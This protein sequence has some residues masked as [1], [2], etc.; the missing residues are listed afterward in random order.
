[1]PN[2][3]CCISPPEMLELKAY[4]DIS[5][6]GVIA[7]FIGTACLAVLLLICN[8]LACFDPGADPFISD[9]S[10]ALSTPNPAH[11]GGGGGVSA[12]DD[13]WH[14]NPVDR[15]F[16][17]WIR[18]IARDWC[19][20]RLWASSMDVG[21]AFIECITT[22]SDLQ[23]ITGIAILISGFVSLDCTPGGISA[24]HWAM[25]VGLSRL[26]T[27][28]HLA[29]LSVLRSYLRQRRWARILRFALTA[30]LLVL[31][32]A[33]MVPTVFFNWKDRS[34]V[35]YDTRGQSLY[36]S[37][38]AANLSSPAICFF[39]VSY[40]RFEF[41]RVKGIWT[42]KK[43]NDAG[44]VRFEITS[45]MQGMVIS[46]TLLVLSFCTRTLKLFK[47]VSVKFRCIWR[48]IARGKP[49][50]WTAAFLR[51]TYPKS[52]NP[53]S[54]LVRWWTV[55]V[56]HPCLA[57]ILVTRIT[58][59]LTTSLLFEILVLALSLVWGIC[60]LSDSRQMDEAKPIIFE[61]SKITFGQ[62]LPLV[63]LAAQVFPVYIAF[64]S[65]IKLS[66]TTRKHVRASL[67][68][69]FARLCA[70]FG[71]TRQGDRPDNNTTPL[72]GLPT[73]AR[74]SSDPNN[75]RTELLGNQP[76]NR[77]STQRPST[78]TGVVEIVHDALTRDYYA[79]APWISPCITFMA[80][81]ITAKA[82]ALLR[83]YFY[84]PYYDFGSEGK[85]VS[86]TEYSAISGA[87]ISFFLGSPMMLSGF[88]LLGLARNRFTTLSPRRKPFRSFNVTL[89]SYLLV[90]LFF[91]HFTYLELLNFVYIILPCSL[92]F[93]YFVCSIKWE[94]EAA[95]RPTNRA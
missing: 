3:S 7:S 29:A 31:Q 32:I 18:G 64:E 15:M 78:T 23:A 39:D 95:R 42:A 85:R 71:S 90:S 54:A 20:F 57:L 70:L 45:A 62:I 25:V 4:G 50:I 74:L 43:D 2:R 22:M 55:L 75:S 79:T 46:A 34:S 94:V 44:K 24:Y 67:R 88:T 59:D 89:G 36:F 63:L 49:R 12:T 56:L 82:F 28:T 30:T 66:W 19:G 73:G 47:P 68:P 51:R 14:P 10:L 52:S 27:V 11:G 38:S 41:E 48:W 84:P 69:T 40:G 60:S 13:G 21:Q 61:E 65:K 1:M 72:P 9:A 37:V 92:W 58:T 33:A 26:S 76:S 91:T 5:G 17:D 35:S 8:Y 87:Y 80:L 81:D 86:F 93:L 16:L 53:N 77:A 6:P 83:F